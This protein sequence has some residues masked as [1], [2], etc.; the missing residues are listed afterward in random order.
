MDFGS[1]RIGYVPY[2][3][4]LR[5][6]GDRYRFCYYAQKRNIRFE[7]ADVSER[8]D[9]LVVSAGADLSTWRRYPKKDTKIVFQY[10]NSYL[11]EQIA[12]PRRLFRGLAKFLLRQNQYMLVDHCDGIRDMCALADA[13]A[14][15]TIEQQRDVSEFCNNS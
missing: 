14:C 4:S 11:A 1:R 10:I 2:D 3:R 5:Q 9:L 7:I 12:S 6:P 15:T 8:Y 13:V